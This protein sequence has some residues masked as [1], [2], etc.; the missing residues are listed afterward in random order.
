[1][2]LD[3][4]AYPLGKLLVFIY[5]TLAFNN[6]GL[7]IIIFTILI[8]LLLMP[9]TF[10][11]YKSTLAMQEIQPEI[12]NIQKRY[13]NDKE[14]L[15]QEIMKLYSEHKINP[16]AGCL[17][18]LIQLPIIIAL[19]WVIVQPL[20]FMLLK[21]VEQIDHIVGVAAAANTKMSMLQEQ[22]AA[23]NFFNE[24]RDAL[25][26]VAGSLSAN[27]LIDFNF[28]GLKLGYTASYR[29]AE[30]MADPLTYL[31]LLLLPAIGV[32]VTYVAT[33]M[34]MPKNTS[35]GSGDQ[36]AAMVGSMTNSMKYFAPLMTL[37]FSFQLP[38]GVVLYW[39]ASYAFQIVQ[40]FFINKYAAKRKKE[41]EEMRKARLAAEIAEL[42]EKRRQEREAY[43][44]EKQRKKEEIA[45]KLKMKD[46]KS[47]GSSG[48]KKKKSY[49]KKGGGKK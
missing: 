6:Y 21:T 29:P 3:F 19:Y 23:L 17:P 46:I 48:G 43:E 24:N 27:E 1:M 7:A 31:P 34:A 13:R 30:I 38:A 9:L 44:A 15:N 11:Q 22:L 28:L 33:A 16:M 49:K 10:K 12:Q 42:E 35:S 18:L 14:K 25:S 36:A 39:I 47:S 41:M 8:K 5:N 40:Q 45:M 2:N 4:I 20:K 37:I 26:Q 32:V